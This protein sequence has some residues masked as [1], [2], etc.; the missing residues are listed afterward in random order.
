MQPYKNF[1][2]C[3]MNITAKRPKKNRSGCTAPGGAVTS[4]FFHGRP[5]RAGVS[6]SQLESAIA[7]G[8]IRERIYP[9]P[10]VREDKFF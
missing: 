8:A 2:R 5:E 4:A 9:S 6:Q 10:R 1:G 3:R 7:D